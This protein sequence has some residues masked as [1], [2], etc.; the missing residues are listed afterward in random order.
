MCRQ[1]GFYEGNLKAL[2]IGRGVASPSTLQEG[3]WA[4]S[5]PTSLSSLPLVPRRSPVGQTQ[6]EVSGHRSLWLLLVQVS[7]PGCRARQKRRADVESKEIIQHNPRGSCSQGHRICRGRQHLCRE[8]N[9]EAECSAVIQGKW[10]VGKEGE[11][12]VS[13]RWTQK[14]EQKTSWQRRN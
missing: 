2:A 9:C 7:P 14:D 10:H 1:R 12:A 5:I 6:L 3:S 11:G 13:Q 4:I 8:L